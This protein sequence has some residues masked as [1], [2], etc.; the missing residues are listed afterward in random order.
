MTARLRN[1]AGTVTAFVVCF[2]LA[3]IAVAGLVVDGGSV[4]AARRETFEEADAAARAG[5]QAVDV[6]AL[7]RGAPITLDPSRAEHLAER[8]LAA[9]GASGSVEVDGDMITVTVTR[10]QTLSILGVVGVGPMTIRASGAA[11]AEDRDNA[12][13]S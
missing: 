2:T 6:G 4:L 3:L 8:Q 11:R 13:G 12:S 5:A 10:V 7:R 1:D 9:A